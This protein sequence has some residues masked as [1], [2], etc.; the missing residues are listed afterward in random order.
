MK[1]KR[2][3]PPRQLPNH[4]PNRR[5]AHPQKTAGARRPSAWARRPLA[6]TAETPLLQIEHGIAAAG[7][8]GPNLIR[9]T[10]NDA[11]GAYLILSMEVPAPVILAYETWTRFAAL[12]YFMHAAHAVDQFDGSRMTW[13]LETPFD[14]FAW[15]ATVTEVVPFDLIVWKSVVGMPHPNFGSVGFE[16]VNASRT[17]VTVQV[18]FD[19]RGPAGWPGDPLPALTPLLE[20]S[21]QRFHDL[22]AVQALFA[23]EH[24]P[25]A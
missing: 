9:S 22:M 23:E 21:L 1:T 5:Q 17:V 6:A 11:D 2:Y 7:E 16:P 10:A 15:Q 12:P 24:L 25:A 20:R 4:A 13:C 14:Q 8:T 18:G 3:H 19:L